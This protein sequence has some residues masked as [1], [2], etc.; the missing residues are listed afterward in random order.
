M[1]RPTFRQAMIEVGPGAIGSLVI[2]FL[3][4]F[5]TD[6]NG[7]IV[8]GVSMLTFMMMRVGTYFWLRRK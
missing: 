8:F 4:S 7:S 2:F 3:L 6:L 1:E 5:A